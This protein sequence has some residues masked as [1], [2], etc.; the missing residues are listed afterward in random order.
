M[1]VNVLVL[2]HTAELGGAEMAA[3]RPSPSPQPSTGRRLGVSKTMAGVLLGLA[4]AQGLL[5]AWFFGSLS[6]KSHADNRAAVPVVSAA[7]TEMPFA[8]AIVDGSTSP[9]EQATL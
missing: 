6:R 3:P 5:A 9:N 4:C 2:G 1:R 7:P 8:D